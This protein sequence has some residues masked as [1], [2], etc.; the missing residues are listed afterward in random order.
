MP[1]PEEVKAICREL[2]QDQAAKE[3][4]LTK[5]QMNWILHG[6]KRR[7]VKAAS[8]DFD[9]TCPITGFKLVP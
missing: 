2:T 5:G 6:K 7:E 8:F 4:G 1:T 9:N 3:L